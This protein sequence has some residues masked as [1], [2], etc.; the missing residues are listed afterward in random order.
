LIAYWTEAEKGK[1]HEVVIPY[2]E[3]LERQHQPRIALDKACLRLVAGRPPLGA[4]TRRPD[5]S[6]AALSAFDSFRSLGPN[7]SREVVGGALAMC[8]RPM[9]VK[10][11]PVGADENIRTFCHQASKLVDGVMTAERWNEKFQRMAE[12]SMHVTL[13]AVKVSVDGSSQIRL[14][15][16]D[17]FGLFW[18]LYD[19]EQPM[20]LV[21]IHAV[22]RR[23]LMADHPAHADHIKQLPSWY[24]E[25]IP[26]VDQHTA[27]GKP[28]CVRV[29]EATC[30]KYGNQVGRHVICV[31]GRDLDDVPFEDEEHD[32]VPLRWE[33]DPRGWGGI[34][35]VR[36]CA[37]YHAL[38]SRVTKM[39]TEQLKG[40]VPIIWVNDDE[41]TFKNISDLEYQIGRYSG[42]QPP[43]IEIAGAYDTNIP[44]IKR[45]IKEDCYHENG[46][47]KDMST[48]SSPAGIT[49]EPGRREWVETVNIRNIQRQYRIEQ[50]WRDVANKIARK[51]STAY[52][53]KGAVIR[54][55]GSDFLEEITWPDLEENQYQAVARTASGLSLTVSGQMDQL[56]RLVKLK[57]IDE[58]DVSTH[59]RLPD[60]EAETER[61]SSPTDLAR[62]QIQDILDGKPTSP[63][64]DQDHAV[65]IREATLELQLQRKKGI[66]SEPRMQ[67][68][69]RYIRKCEAMLTPPKTVDLSA[70]TASAASDVMTVN[71]LRARNGGAGPMMNPDGTPD[72]VGNMTLAQFRAQFGG[73]PEEPPAVGVP[74]VQGGDPAA[75]APEATQPAA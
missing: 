50:C 45:Q 34:S 16:V 33:N 64:A 7:L 52:K 47:S 37:P 8:V 67:A 39:E 4:S 9:Q 66:V 36:G 44:E 72:P 56:E 13:G 59:L 58:R 1:V 60:T 71:E 28:D 74:P 75:Q 14:T 31:Q 61:R 32:I 40:R 54:A 12:T 53:D 70:I 51:A 17:T 68:L 57:V 19:G 6:F 62:K 11:M 3:T 29:I 46:V 63:F 22:P 23:R 21:E 27:L 69:R 20:T 49:S 48:G 15:L 73:K 18:D 55:P 10:I 2:A 26:G 24:P 35:L 30:V 5:G 65:A 42:A 38:L 25:P 41:D 43:K